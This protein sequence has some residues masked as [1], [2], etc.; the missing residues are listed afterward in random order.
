MRRTNASTLKGFTPSIQAQAQ[1]QNVETSATNTT[2]NK[3]TLDYQTS[4]TSAMDAFFK[5]TL[6]RDDTIKELTKIEKQIT[7]T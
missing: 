1:T 2:V 3:I 7:K 5:K 6:S 4:I